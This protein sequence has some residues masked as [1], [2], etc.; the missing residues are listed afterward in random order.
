MHTALLGKDYAKFYEAFQQGISTPKTPKPTATILPAKRSAAVSTQSSKRRKQ[1]DRVS[2]PHSDQA[3]ARTIPTQQ[4]A[5]TTTKVSMGAKSK[6]IAPPLDVARES[7]VAPRPRSH[8]EAKGKPLRLFIVLYS[9]LYTF[10]EF[11]FCFLLIK[12]FY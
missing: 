11:R 8:S 2:L 7:P 9:S 3:R 1:D 4:P 6:E 12:L 10:R 5:A